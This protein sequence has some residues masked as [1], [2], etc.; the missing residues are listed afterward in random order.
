MHKA[1]GAK[2]EKG[3]G[4]SAALVSGSSIR[5]WL[6]R[7]FQ[8]FFTL[9]T[10]W[11]LFAEFTPALQDYIQARRSERQQLEH[12]MISFDAIE[13]E[14]QQLESLQLDPQ[15]I[16]QELDRQSLLPPGHPARRAWTELK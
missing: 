11:L 6:P 9:A 13:R 3:T 7:C 14:Q 10:L 5:D 8:A 12:L 4:R 1:G 15:R 16:E 2:S